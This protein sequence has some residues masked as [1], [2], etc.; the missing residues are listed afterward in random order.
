MEQF[1]YAPDIAETPFLPEEE[2]QHCLKVL[3]H[4]EGDAITL[5]DGRG[6]AYKALIIK[7]N[8]RDCLLEIT[9]RRRMKS[10]R[11]YSLHLAVAPTKNA[12]RM[13]WLVEKATE[14]GC[15]S[16]TFLRCFNSERRTLKTERME[17]IAVSAMKQSQKYTLPRINEMIDFKEFIS[18]NNEVFKAIAHCRGEIKRMLLKDI[19]PQYSSALVL[20]GPEGDFTEEEI[21]MAMQQGFISITLGESRLRTETA[22]L[23]ACI[24][25][26]FLNQ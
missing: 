2:A 11:D 14:I 15:D 12:D 20:T 3:R 7:G 5:T 23:T 1:F 25:I 21:E 24:M 16:I 6:M 4:K 17:R 10:E 22:A 18:Q 26:N 13:E 9:E 8:P 19:Y